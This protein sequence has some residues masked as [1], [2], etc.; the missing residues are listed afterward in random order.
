MP[1]GVFLWL[2]PRFLLS[3]IWGYLWGIWPGIFSVA[4][5]ML[6]EDYCSTCWPCTSHLIAERPLFVQRQLSGKDHMGRFP[7]GW[8]FPSP[9]LL[10]Q[11]S[12][13]GLFL[14]HGVPRVC[15]LRVSYIFSLFFSWL[16]RLR[17]SALSLRTLFLW[18]AFLEGFALVFGVISVFFL[19]SLA[20]GFSAI[21]R[22]RR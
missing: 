6:P 17:R 14:H 13:H 20:C 12:P 8:A 10:P 9:S 22:V 2:T 4:V 3:L 1:G 21:F 15:C 18:F 16:K 5:F 19:F 11:V 7:P